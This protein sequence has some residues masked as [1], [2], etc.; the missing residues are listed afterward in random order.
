[1]T[2]DFSPKKQL[3]P[4]KGGGGRKGKTAIGSGDDGDSGD[5][6]TW[7]A[8]EGEQGGL[9]RPLTAVCDESLLL[10]FGLGLMLEPVADVCAD[11]ACGR[12]TI[13]LVNRIHPELLIIDANL[14]LLNGV[15]LCNRV[16]QDSPD[17]R[18]V[19]YTDSFHMARYHQQFVRAG[20][21]AFCLKSS[22]PQVLL[23]AIEHVNLNQPFCDPRIAQLL[24]QDPTILVLDEE[25]TEREID[26][27]V[28]LDLSDVEIAIQLGLEVSP[29]DVKSIA[30][31]LQKKLNLNTR[32]EALHKAEQLGLRN[33]PPDKEQRLAIAEEKATAERY[34]RHAIERWIKHTR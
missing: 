32:E 14:P 13:E 11:S 33:S 1:M 4:Q 29:E 22:E 19:V 28:R 9:R 2:E 20:V 21:S 27:L 12:S 5:F 25:L 6:Q 30:D 31:D 7:S 10:R 26:V 18:F 16:L 17:T 24:C 23:S 15:Q 8:R 3:E 34:A